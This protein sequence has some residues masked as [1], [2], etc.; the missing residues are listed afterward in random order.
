[1]GCSRRLTAALALSVLLHGLLLG[2]STPPQPA[3]P[4]VPLPLT[5]ALPPPAGGHAPL[6]APGTAPATVP[7]GARHMH[8]PLPPAPVP[9]PAAPGRPAAVPDVRRSPVLAQPAAPA[10]TPGA[11]TP[12]AR[13]T[14]G[15]GAGGS[16][17]A[18]VGGNGNGNGTG[19]VLL[20]P[21]RFLGDVR[22]PPYPERSRELGEQGRVE[23]RVKIG[24]DGQL[25]AL[26]VTRPSG[27]AR[28]DDAAQ[29]LVR[30]GPFAPARRN[31]AAIES[32]L[33]LGVPFR[34]D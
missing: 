20:T 7:R 11:G 12:T 22:H 15:S 5:V 23:L 25:L 27:Y 21:A 9:A 32:W 19:S 29:A 1:M 18:T 6:R 31:G 10:G 24:V 16:G 3:R 30:R 33:R 26:E 8:R 34:L 28:L 4:G 2:L 13:A 17:N 14:T